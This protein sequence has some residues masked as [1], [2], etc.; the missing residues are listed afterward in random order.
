MLC[1][2][3]DLCIILSMK[4]FYPFKQKR[5][6]LILSILTIIIL[7]VCIL[8]NILRVCEVGNLVS[9]YHTQDILASV[10]M[11]FVIVVL[12]LTIFLNGLLVKDTYMLY[13][14]GFLVSKVKYEDII[15]IRQD[16][17]NKFLLIYYKAKG[18]GMVQDKVTGISADVLQINCNGKYFDEILDKIKQANPST[19]IEF[20]TYQPPKK[21]K[22]K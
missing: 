16:T 5:W 4:K 18:K 20:V 12:A 9:Y 22:E 8:V 14:L 6:I 13:L 19:L 10:I 15:V 17:D 7:F 21:N 1:T 11:G 2:F 3:N